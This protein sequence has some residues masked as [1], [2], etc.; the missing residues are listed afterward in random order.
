MLGDVFYFFVGVF[1]GILAA[2][3]GLGGGFLIV[4]ALDLLGAGIHQAIG[5]SS[6]SI[7][8]TSLSAIIAYSRQKRIHYRAGFLL[9]AP[10]IV[11]A[12]AGAWLTSF[13]D[14]AQLKTI[15][16]LALI[17]VAL[18]MFRGRAGESAV[19]LD[20]VEFNYKLILIAGLSAGLV[21]GLLGVGGGIINVPV[22]VALGL[23]IH[24]AVATSSF[25][26]FFTVMSGAAK[27]YLLGNVDL[28][29]LVPLVPGLVAGA[30]IG[31]MVARK[32][33]AGS[34]KRGFAAV[35]ALIALRMLL[36]S[37]R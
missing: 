36:E 34:L 26:M 37:L 24:Y 12:Y 19:K 23:P 1:V 21:S 4:P 10:S 17:L 6:A 27:H 15:F 7:P 14:P 35:L 30:Q 22:L 8:F 13:L 20:G 2:L 16:G 28:G 9:A 11:G 3:F 5:T 33:K 25:V 31:A 18:R 29:L 32:I